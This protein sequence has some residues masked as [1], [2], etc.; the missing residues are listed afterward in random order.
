MQL[1]N[2]SDNVW[3]TSTHGRQKSVWKSLSDTPNDERA[4]YA[5]AQIV[6]DRI[7]T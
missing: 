2:G 3:P 1:S 6:R 4:A 7:V 5:Y